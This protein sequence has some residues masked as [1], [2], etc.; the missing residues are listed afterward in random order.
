[1]GW[2]PSAIYTVE[3]ERGWKVERFRINSFVFERAKK[4]Y[5]HFQTKICLQL[6]QQIEKDFGRDPG[7]VYYDELKLTKVRNVPEAPK[8]RRSTPRGSR[9]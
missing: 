3:H 9:R 7:F 1:M 5:T 6:R 4:G 8:H 2:G